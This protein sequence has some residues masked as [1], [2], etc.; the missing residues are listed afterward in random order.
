MANGFVQLDGTFTPVLSGATHERTC[1][2]NGTSLQAVLD[3]GVVRVK[4][5]DD[6]I[7]LESS[8]MPND[9][10]IA[11]IGRVLR[12]IDCYYICIEFRGGLKQKESPRPIRIGHFRRM[13]G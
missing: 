3:R 6:N 9:D 8:L 11:G 1:E 4:V 7:A 13:I 5:Y 12:T 10:Q 2:L